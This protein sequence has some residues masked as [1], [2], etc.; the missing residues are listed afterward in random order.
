MCQ[1]GRRFTVEQE[2]HTRKPLHGANQQFHQRLPPTLRLGLI[3]LQEER[4]GREGGSRC[5]CDLMVSLSDDQRCT[6][7][8]Q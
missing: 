8:G 6:A 1:C 3:D 4:V 2:S 5:S 7:E